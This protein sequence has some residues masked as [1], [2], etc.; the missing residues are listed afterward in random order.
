MQILRTSSVGPEESEVVLVLQLCG[1]REPVTP[2]HL[3]H[4]DLG[5]AEDGRLI[6]LAENVI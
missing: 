2:L 1:Q 3:R 6:L 4:L 5:L